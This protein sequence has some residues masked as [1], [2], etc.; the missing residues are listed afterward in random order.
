MHD[1]GGDI[2]D[3]EHI[4]VRFGGKPEH[5]IEFDGAVAARE[6][7][8]AGG[9]QILLGEILIDGVTQALRARLRRKGEAGLSPLLQPLHQRHGEIVRAQG[10]QRK[11]QVPRGAEFLQI[12]AQLDKA[13]IV[14]R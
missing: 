11:V 1:V 5:E 10:R 7:A 2:G 8:A 4:L 12:V 9:E 14:G 3:T 13:G 6:R